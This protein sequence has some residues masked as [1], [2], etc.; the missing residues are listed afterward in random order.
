MTSRVDEL[1]EEL[2][3]EKEIVPAGQAD[4]ETFLR[5][6]YLDVIGRVPTIAEYNQFF[7]LD[8]QIRR[9]ELIDDLLESREHALH[10]GGIWKRVLVPDDE[11]AISRLGGSGKLEQ[12]LS[13]SFS[14]NLRY[15]DLVK[16][17]LLAEGRVNESGP[18]LFYACLL[19]TSPSPRDRQKSRMPSSA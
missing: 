15:D 12:W 1:V 18:L 16:Q 3:T 10:M 8:S 7:E 17:L 11:T 9:G 4:D 6:V 2:W 5:R 19:Y 14:K 13:D